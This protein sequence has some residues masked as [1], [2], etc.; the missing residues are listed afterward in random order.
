MQMRL[1]T[2]LIGGIGAIICAVA[3]F[4]VIPSQIEQTIHG[5]EYIDSRLIPRLVAGL[6]A[7]C[8]LLL[9]VKS[10]VFKQEQIREISVPAERRSLAFFLPMLVF[11]LAMPRLGYLASGIG[12][13]VATL[14]F[15]RVGSVKQYIAVLLIILAVYLAFVHGLGVPLP[16]LEM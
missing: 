11:L 16:Q 12:M 2:N 3:L 9:V 4:L 7:L 15:Q 5:N 8:G 10:L 13:A 6:I 14:L 1:R